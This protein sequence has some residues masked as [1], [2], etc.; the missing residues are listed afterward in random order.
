MS[1]KNLKYNYY[2]GDIFFIRKEQKIEG[3]QY[4]VARMNKL[5]LK[6]IVECVDLTAAAYPIPRN[7]RER[8]ENILLPRL[9]EIKDELDNDKSLTD[10]LGIE[11]SKL[12]QE[13]IV[14][15]LESSSMQK[16]LKERGYKPE[17]LKNLI[18]NVQFMK[19]KN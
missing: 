16:L 7:L 18:S 6:G 17:E 2:E 3:M 15:G 1:P 8:L 12:N 13:D 5:Q 14:Y 9:Y 11:L 4:A 10:S 19:Y